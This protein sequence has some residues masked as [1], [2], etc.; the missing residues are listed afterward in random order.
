MDFKLST[1]QQA[2]ADSVSRFCSKEYDFKAR[3]DLTMTNEGFSRAHWARFADLGWL[4]AGLSEENGGF[5]GSA[6]ETA[7]IME[8]FGRALVVEP[9]LST[10]VYA[11]QLLA[12]LPP[13]PVRDAMIQRAVAG[14]S[15]LAVAH[16]EPTARGDVDHVATTATQSGTQW[17]LRGHKSMVLGAPSADQILISAKS[18]DGVGLFL[19]T[20]GTANMRMRPYRTLD[21]MRVADIWLEDAPAEMLAPPDRAMPALIL[22]HDHTLVAICAE[23][24]GASEAALFITRDYLKTR[25]QFGTTLNTFQALQHRMADMLVEVEL[26]R[27]ILYQALAALTA[28]AKERA[29]AVSAMKAFVSSAA[30][31]VGRN[32]VQLHGGMGMT[33]EYPIGH[34]YRRLFVIANQFGNESQHL[35]RYAAAAAPLWPELE[36]LSPHRRAS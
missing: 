28:P 17:Q 20:P 5:G 27:S 6:I 2:L 18:A 8:G 16:G 24:V 4:G 19:V 26:S 34:Y 35:K 30:M 12:A 29:R 1:E 9:F 32:A 36:A 23:A 13:A 15:L 31:F 14:E 3:G 25:T 10:A 11:V 22:G 33:E 7:I 21:N